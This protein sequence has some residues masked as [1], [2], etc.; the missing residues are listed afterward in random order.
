MWSRTLRFQ[1]RAGALH[2]VVSLRAESP[3]LIHQPTALLRAKPAEPARFQ[4]RFVPACVGRQA[5]HLD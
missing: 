2:I 5:A 4:R 3:Q 1:A